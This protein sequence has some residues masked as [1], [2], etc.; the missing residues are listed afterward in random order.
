[1]ERRIEEKGMRGP[2]LHGMVN[3]QHPDA[4]GHRTIP[5]N[6]GKAIEFAWDKAAAMSVQANL[7]TMVFP[8]D[9]PQG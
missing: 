8:E 7:H 1:M 4:T 2:E 3:I 9:L 6:A 5:A